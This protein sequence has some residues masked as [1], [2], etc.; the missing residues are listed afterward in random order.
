MANFQW[1]FVPINFYIMNNEIIERLEKIEHE[2]SEYN[3]QIPPPIRNVEKFKEEYLDYFGQVVDEQIIEFY[4]IHDGLDE[5]GYQIYSSYDHI[6][7]KVEYGIFQN[8]ELLYEQDEDDKK[9]IFFAVSGMDLY[10]FNKEEKEY[11]LLD[12]ASGDKY[13]SFKDFDDMLL[14]I[15]KL[16]LYEDAD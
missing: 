15:L 8:N 9:Y 11:Q 12:R 13:N 3:L 4:Q 14:Y 5:N 10:V 6:I 7:N 16:M 2:R 1:L